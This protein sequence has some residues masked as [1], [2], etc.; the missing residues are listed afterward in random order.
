[1]HP[2]GTAKRLPGKVLPLMSHLTGDGMNDKDQL[3]IPRTYS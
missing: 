1:M 3:R 2:E